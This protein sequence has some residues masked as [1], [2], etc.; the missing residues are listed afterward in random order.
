MSDHDIRRVWTDD[1]LDSALATLRADVRTAAPVLAEARAAL[2]TTI[3]QAEPARGKRPRRS[4]RRWLAGAAAVAVL[5]AGTLL[6]QT[7]SFGGPAP[8]TAE[9]V[10]TLDRAAAQAIG[11]VDG[12]V[13]PGRYR[14]VATHAWWMGSTT[15]MDGREFAWLSEHLQETWAPANPE[16]EWLL[17]QEI[18][19]NVQ[20]VNST[21]EEADAAGVRTDSRWPE[22][23]W[24]APCGDFFGGSDCEDPGSWQKPTAQW[25]AGLPTD[26]AALYERLRADAPDDRGDAALLTYAADALRSGL[27]GADLRAALYRALTRLPGLEVTE[28][29]ANLDGRVGIALGVDDGDRRHDII[30]DPETGLFLGER[31]VVTDWLGEFDT[32]TVVSFTS[33]TTGVVDTIGTQPAG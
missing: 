11:A 7:V 9:A 24:R 27:I 21:A 33:V 8:A 30:I 12:P 19:G 2:I 17:R 26:P 16:D 20:W 3:E 29:Q 14:Y 28:R 1:E 25:Q 23:E 32:G 10:Q 18:T 13:G 15:S 4:T 31:Q 5:V 6:V 22:G